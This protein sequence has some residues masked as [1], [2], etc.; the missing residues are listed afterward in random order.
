MNR[1]KEFVLTSLAI[2]VTM[3]SL[4]GVLKLEQAVVYDIGFER[5]NDS[6]MSDVELMR[7]SMFMEG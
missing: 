1:K 2:I 3:I 5:V 4:V 7:L 6:N